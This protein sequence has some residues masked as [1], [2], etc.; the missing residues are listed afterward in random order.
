M[1]N[2][3]NHHKRSRSQDFLSDAPK[4]ETTTKSLSSLLRRPE[5]GFHLEDK[6]Q[7]GSI[8]NKTPPRRT[9]TSEDAAVIDT[10]TIVGN[11]EF[12]V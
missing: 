2:K 7:A 1:P 11:M 8:P 5:K 12:L 4:K 6:D 9:T 3:P 10:D